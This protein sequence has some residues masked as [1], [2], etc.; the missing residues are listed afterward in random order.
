MQ[1]AGE[2]DEFHDVDPPLA[3]LNAGDDSLRGLEPRRDVVLRELERFAGG[4]EGGAKGAV[5][6]AARRQVVG[7]AAF[8]VKCRIACRLLFGTSVAPDERRHTTQN[9]GQ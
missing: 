5:A 8:G 1:H 4:D 3:N 6:A 7:F 9:L 2:V